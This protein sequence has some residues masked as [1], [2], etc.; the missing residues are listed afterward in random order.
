MK[1]AMVGTCASGKTTI[2]TELRL[3]GHDAYVVSQEHSIVRNLW[4]H[5]QPQLVVLLDVD[6]DTVR[7][8]RGGSWPR[9]LFDLQQERLKHARQNADLVLNSS[10]LTVDE[11]VA[12]ITSL[13]ERRRSES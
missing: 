3:R 10:H 12:S 8:R 2:A 5:Q 11:I 13:I 7:R 6:F 9:W 1:I 4:N